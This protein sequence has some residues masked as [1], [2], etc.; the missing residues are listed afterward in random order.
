MEKLILALLLSISTFFV[1]AQNIVNIQLTSLTTTN[2]QV[3]LTPLEQEI[4][5]LS[6]VVFTLKWRDT[7][8]IALGNP[9]STSLIEITKSGPVR[10]SGGWRYQTY[11]GCGIVSSN[12][13][14]LV[15]NIPRSGRGDIVLTDDPYIQQLSV[16][17]QYF[18]SIGGYN[19]TGQIGTLTRSLSIEQPIEQ[20]PLI[21]LY[22]DSKTSTFYTK[23]EGIFYN[24][25]GQ[26]VTVLNEPEL[27]I[28]RKY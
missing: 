28:V 9:P 8:N 20:D 22:F 15:L 21:I 24:L 11:S 23:K 17:G 16:N 19:V 7:R 25:M 18:V 13:Q 26:R 12:I 27:L 3:T 2:C 1:S 5:T 14:T 6:N 10:T 4:N